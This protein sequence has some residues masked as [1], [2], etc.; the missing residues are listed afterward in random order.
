MRCQLKATFIKISPWLSMGASLEFSGRVLGDGDEWIVKVMSSLGQ[1]ELSRRAP[2]TIG[3]FGLRPDEWLKIPE[4]MSGKK[5]WEDTT[6][7]PVPLW[8]GDF[9]EGSG[10]NWVEGALC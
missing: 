7:K 10:G 2:G 1:R 9:K 5:G 6:P 4:G 3:S 8:K